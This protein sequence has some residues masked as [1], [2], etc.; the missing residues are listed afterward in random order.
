MLSARLSADRPLLSLPS[1]SANLPIG[2]R[3]RPLA[4]ISAPLMSRDIS[5]MPRPMSR[6]GAVL[7]EEVRE[8]LQRVVVGA[9][10]GAGRVEQL[11]LEPACTPPRRARPP[12]RPSP[13]RVAPGSALLPLDVPAHLADVVE[14][15]AH[16]VDPE[17]VVSPCRRP[18]CRT[19]AYALESS[20]SSC[21]RLA[22]V[23][24][25]V[26]PLDV[27][28]QPQRAQP[29]VLGRVR[30]GLD[31]VQSGLSGSGSP[32][33]PARGRCGRRC[34]CRSS[35]AARARS[36]ASGR[37]ACRAPRSLR[38]ASRRR[39]RGSSRSAARAPCP[40]DSTRRS[41]PAWEMLRLAH[42][43]RHTTAAGSA[44]SIA[45]A[46][47]APSHQLLLVQLEQEPVAL[48]ELEPP[49]LCAAA[50]HPRRTDRHQTAVPEPRHPVGP[51][52][53][54]S[55]SPGRAHD[56]RA[57]HRR[58]AD[59]RRPGSHPAPRATPGRAPS[60]SPARRVARRPP[61]RRDRGRLLPP[62]VRPSPRRPQSSS[63]T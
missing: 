11:R 51:S 34:R 57:R 17:L 48:T 43:R 5:K 61:R 18:R 62:G 45:P 38:G 1:A 16:A 63:S 39:L 56:S 30:V 7:V 32:S 42:A 15:L 28:L 47:R 52:T 9:E 53:H 8:R 36:R 49:A 37:S 46:A 44:R 59:R 6:F 2:G 23:A 31:V 19:C 12:R 60:G 22:S 35:A 29:V 26:E 55:S 40:A 54:S 4:F 21:A 50:P 13:D 25:G 20:I 14:P 41:P 3:S 58:G 24:L 10:G 27:L 33:P